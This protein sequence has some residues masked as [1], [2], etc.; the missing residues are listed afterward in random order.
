[1]GVFARDFRVRPLGPVR[2]TPAGAQSP[3]LVETR[4]QACF[5]SPPFTI[6][7]APAF[8]RPLT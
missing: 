7:A 1:V 4:L 3:D 6:R 5:A 2:R 8:G